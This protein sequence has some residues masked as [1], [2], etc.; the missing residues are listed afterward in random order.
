[1]KRRSPPFL[2]AQNHA[3]M[4]SQNRGRDETVLAQ[5]I[6]DPM[7]DNLRP[8]PESVYQ[9]PG[10]A[11]RQRESPWAPS[12]LSASVAVT[13]R[14][15]AARRQR[16][17]EG[18]YAGCSAGTHDPRPRFTAGNR[19]GICLARPATSDRLWAHRWPG[20][21]ARHSLRSMLGE[22]FRRRAGRSARS[23]RSPRRA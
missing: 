1:L 13:R 2:S 15:S 21:G 6:L 18:T 16:G 17:P 4:K 11:H 20:S 9:D 8:Q 7:V 5:T 10:D 23:H 3:N 12:E 22:S 14:R 19:P